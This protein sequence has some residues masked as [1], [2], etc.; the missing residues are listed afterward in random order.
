[1]IEI[2]KVVQKLSREQE[3]AAAAPAAVV[4]Y[5]PVQKHKVTHGKPGWLNTSVLSLTWE[6][7]YLEKKVF[8]LGRGPGF[9][10]MGVYWKK[11]NA[12]IINIPLVWFNKFI[13]GTNTYRWVS[14]RKT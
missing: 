7:P 1:M 2:Q 10:K 3:S 5:E 14:A 13:R 12:F 8:I 4:T 6:S 9:D 11:V